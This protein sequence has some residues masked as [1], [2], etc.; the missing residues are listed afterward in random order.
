MFNEREA[1][2]LRL[3][4]L[5]DKEI[6]VMRELREERESI[7]IKLRELDRGNQLPKAD[8]N[9]S[10]IELASAAA[11]ELKQSKNLSQHSFSDDGTSPLDSE[12]EER[13]RSKTSIQ[14]EA[15]LKILNEH[16][17]GMRGTSLR[18]E[19]EK[20]TG[21]PVKNMTTF[22]NGLM[23]HYPEIEKP[24]RGRYLLKSFQ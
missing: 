1:L 20:E 3:E 5:N 18:T 2:R 4:Q 21:F 6:H 23:K 13:H 8:K 19:I 24:G 17:D 22:M 11:Q 9:S 12:A 15:A 7:Y 14:R 10:L 16:K